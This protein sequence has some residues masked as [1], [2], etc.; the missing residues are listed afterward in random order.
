MKKTTQNIYLL[1]FLMCTLQVCILFIVLKSSCL[2]FDKIILVSSLMIVLVWGACFIYNIKQGATFTINFNNLFLLVFFIILCLTLIYYSWFSIYLRVDAVKRFFEGK[3]FIDTLFHSAIAESIAAN[4][5]PSIQ[6]NAPTYL[7]YHCLSHFI[8]A[9]IS[10]LLNIPCFITYNYLFPVIFIPIFLFLIQKVTLIGK[11]YLLGKS[12]LFLFD[13]I[14]LTG[15]VCGFF[16][17]SIQKKIGCNIHTAVFNSESCMIATILLLLYFYIVYKLRNN[18]NIDTINCGLLIPLFIVVLS[19]A[20]ISFGI[21]FTIGASYYIYRKHF[22]KNKKWFFPIA[23]LLIFYIYYFVQRQLSIH[24]PV[25]LHAGGANSFSLFHYVKTYTKGSYYI[26]L[27]YLFLFFPIICTIYSKRDKLFKKVFK[28]KNDCVFIEMAFF[29]MIG[30]LLPGAFLR[31]N[32]G[33]AFYFV[34][35]VYF[36]SWLLFISNE[37]FNSFPKFLVIII[38]KNKKIV[39][40]YCLLVLVCLLVLPTCIKDVHLKNTI[41]QTLKSRISLVGFRHEIP[42]KIK[43]LFNLPNPIIF[44]N[45]Y[46]M[47]NQIREKTN[48][49]PNDYCA[50]LSSDSEFIKKY[51]S[52]LELLHPQVYYSKPYLAISVYL[53]LPVINS[54]YEENGYFYRGDGKIFGNYEDIAGYSFPPPICNIKITK[55]NMK[56]RAK[57]LGKKY[58]IVLENNYYTVVNVD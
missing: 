5:Y 58:I 40:N 27:H 30:S 44:D 11:N 17:E 36:F 15:C 45:N 41:I 18:K 10:K 42:R 48:D 25:P 3:T 33:S 7:S 54:V 46:I 4:G 50:F 20:K 24:Y 49:S 57:M 51:D 35:P 2:F 26:I 38:Y 19:S 13:Y 37:V 16:N 12:G 56:D 39:T 55:E 23:F 28:Y 6:Q 34:I 43:E 52:N 21:D 9:S 47:F 32:G 14:L 53:G 8:V 1:P 29:L 22:L 31:I